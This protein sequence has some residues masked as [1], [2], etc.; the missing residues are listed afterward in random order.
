[1]KRFLLC[2]V[3]VS[4]WMT[5]FGQVPESVKDHY[6]C[7]FDV[8]TDVVL[9]QPVG[10][11]AKAINVGFAFAGSYV[12]PFGDSGLGFAIGGG[13]TFHKLHS[14]ALPKESI[15][16][17]NLEKLNM[18]GVKPFYSLDSLGVGSYKRNFLQVS[19]F[20][21]P[22]EL[23][24]RSEKGFNV[25]LGMKVSFKIGANSKYKGDDYIFGSEENI[26]IKKSNLDNFA[27]FGLNPVFRIGW[28]GFNFYASY[29]LLPMYEF[30]GKGYLKPISMGI[31][32]TPWEFVK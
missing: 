25:S 7:N 19:Y 32:L 27:S 21:V 13:F 20:D 12:I 18:D 2:I 4:A 9:Q 14:N 26:K 29:A 22:L 3:L 23:L 24:Y 28:K 10:Y 5:S 6:Y 1:M 30:E 31:S 11:K 8:F 17:A 15:P 16:L